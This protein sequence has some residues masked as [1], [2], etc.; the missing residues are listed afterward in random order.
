MRFRWHATREAEEHLPAGCDRAPLL[1][2]EGVV[3]VD[4]PADYWTQPKPVR[5]SACPS[6]TPIKPRGPAKSVIAATGGV[7]YAAA[8]PGLWR[9]LVPRSTAFPAPNR[10]CVVDYPQDA[11]RRAQDVPSA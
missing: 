5:F 8:V 3:V 1:F 11:Q 7:P 6:G 4:V 2:G 10:G 9:H